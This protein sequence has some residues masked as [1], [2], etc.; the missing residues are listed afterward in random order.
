M[1]L[2]I[3]SVV[4]ALALVITTRVVFTHHSYVAVFDV[5][6]KV[7]L[8]GTLT[9]VDW[10]NPHVAVFLD[11]KDAAGQVEAWTFE[12]SPPSFFSRRNI[13]KTGFQKAIGSAVGVEAYRAKDGSL[14]GSLL[15]LTF[16]DGTIVINDPSD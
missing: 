4:I 16:A 11:A 8:T 1:S 6:N 12:A 7:V 10:R 3:R 2:P 14:F 13:S 5:N 15:K 9:K